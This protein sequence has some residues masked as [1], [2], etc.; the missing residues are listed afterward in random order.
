MKSIQLQLHK[1]KRMNKKASNLLPD[2]VY[3]VIIAV[4]G[5]VILFGLAWKLMGLFTEQNTLERAEKQ[6]DNLMTDV[7]L[8]KEGETKEFNLLYPGD[9]ALTGWPHKKGIYAI[10]ET[11]TFGLIEAEELIPNTCKKNEWKNCICLCYF[12]NNLL[13][14]I[15]SNRFGSEGVLEG[16]NEES[17]CREINSESFVVNPSGTSFH[18]PII[19]NSLVENGEHLIIKKEGNKLIIN[20]GK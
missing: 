13:E 14:Q 1:M 16:C 7:N 20:A 18:Y 8:L 3:G 15:K 11:I 17:V 9:W 2:N 10:A 4:I 12:S 5:L 19:I 6:M